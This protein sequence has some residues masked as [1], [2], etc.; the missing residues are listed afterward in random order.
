VSLKKLPVQNVLLEEETRTHIHTQTHTCRERER[1]RERGGGGGGGGGGGVYSESYTRGEKEEEEEE[2]EFISH[3]KFAR[4]F[5]TRWTNTLS[6]YATLK[7]SAGERVRGRDRHTDT[8][9]HDHHQPRFMAYL[10]KMG[11]RIF[12]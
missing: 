10:S 9:S 2:E 7:Q 6:R 3:L 11:G 12:D 1:E 8:K 5:L 4:R